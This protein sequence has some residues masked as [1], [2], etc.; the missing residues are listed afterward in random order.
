M[1]TKKGMNR[2]KKIKN[3]EEIQRKQCRRIEREGETQGNDHQQEHI[4]K[5]FLH[6]S[7]NLPNCEGTKAHAFWFE[8]QARAVSSESSLKRVIIVTVIVTERDRERES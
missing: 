8:G 6:D 7:S 4:A 2:E 1:E 3:E 5:F